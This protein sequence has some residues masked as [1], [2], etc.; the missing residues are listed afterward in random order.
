M[1]RDR[2]T[3]PIIMPIYDEKGN[4]QILTFGDVDDKL[5]GRRVINE[6]YRTDDNISKLSVVHIDE[7]VEVSEESTPYFTDENSHN[8]LEK[9]D[10]FTEAQ[11]SS[12]LKTEIFII[13]LLT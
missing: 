5:N 4:T 10:G 1:N 9:T 11:T 7:I 8:W 6:L 3:S 2:L 13:L 12:T